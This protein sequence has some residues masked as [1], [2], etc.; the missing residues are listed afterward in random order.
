MTAEQV[1]LMQK[2]VDSFDIYSEIAV[3]DPSNSTI[4]VISTN[5]EEKIQLI[6]LQFKTWYDA[7]NVFDF[8]YITKGLITYLV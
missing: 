8:K 2:I 1:I 3:S 4:L 6:E 7:N 5:D